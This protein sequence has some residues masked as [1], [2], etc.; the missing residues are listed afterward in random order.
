[1]EQLSKI[2]YLGYRTEGA[3]HFQTFF[4]HSFLPIIEH[5]YKP[6]MVSR[7]QCHY[8]LNAQ[9]SNYAYL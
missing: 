8:T 1:M 6:H 2:Q 4:S 5:K 9:V 3:K 7:R